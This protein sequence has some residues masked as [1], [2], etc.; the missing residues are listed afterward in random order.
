MP[1]IKALVINRL[2]LVDHKQLGRSIVNRL[3]EPLEYLAKKGVLQFEV[4]N[5]NEI[6]IENLKRNKFDVA[7]IN[8]SCDKLTLEIAKVIKSLKIKIIYDLDDNIFNFPSYSNGKNENSWIGFEIIKISSRVI[9]CNL[10]L[11]RLIWK[12]LKKRTTIIEHG[13]NVEKYN[14]NN[15]RKESI[16]PKIVF[17]NADNLKFN[18]FRGEFILA[19]HKL[20][21]E[22]PD[23]EINIYSDQKRILGDEIKY[24][25][26]GSKSYSEH[27]LELAK[28]DYWFGIVPLAGSEEP[29]L[30]NF[31][32]CKSPIKYLDYGMSSI[33]SI[34]SDAYIY[35]GI[36]KH[37]DTGILARNDHSR[38]LYWMR[39]LILDIELR[40]KL[41]SNAYID[42]KENHN[43][44]QMGDKILDVI[45]N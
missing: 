36:V 6:N 12:Y 37:L 42:V 27:K 30:I 44:N 33:P 41:G 19:L 26:L 39:R 4:L 13:I 10:P 3:T 15:Q 18:N 24:I 21:E 22:F 8:K 7:F 45:L 31:H 29:E 14:F 38:W 32:K 28:S 25:D 35:Q 20:Q 11:D 1:K 34:F 43:I 2:S 9:T 23:L 17:T 40:K 5:P 16:H